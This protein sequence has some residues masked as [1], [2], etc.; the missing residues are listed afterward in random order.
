MQRTNE[1]DNERYKTHGAKQGV[2]MVSLD[3]YKSEGVK[4]RKGGLKRLDCDFDRLTYDEADWWTAGWDQ[5]DARQKAKRIHPLKCETCEFATKLTLDASKIICSDPNHES[6]PNVYAC[7]KQNGKWMPSTRDGN[8]ISI[9]GCA[10]HQNFKKQFLDVLEQLYVEFNT[11]RLD[12]RYS[13]MPYA[14]LDGKCDAIDIAI[15]KV[16]AIK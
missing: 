7:S 11:E 1:T 4:A 5:E 2:S 13:D 8:P 3:Y 14:Y 15:Q 12:S 10:S 16:E 9:V 6:Y